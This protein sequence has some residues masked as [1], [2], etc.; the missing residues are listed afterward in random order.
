MERAQYDPRG[1]NGWVM[2]CP[3]PM[4]SSSPS[5][6][7][8]TSGSRKHACKLFWD[9]D[10]W[11]QTSRVRDPFCDYEARTG[12]N[13]WST[14]FDGRGL[15]F[16]VNRKTASLPHGQGVPKAPPEQWPISAHL[17]CGL[18]SEGRKR[19]LRGKPGMNCMET[20]RTAVE[21]RM[22]YDDG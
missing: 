16:S 20:R 10:P 17:P 11:G 21:R 3:R 18:Q 1:G 22:K 13:C 7:E 9:A 8:N 14:N 5:M 2:N 6:K 19:W 15:G 12:G 4:F